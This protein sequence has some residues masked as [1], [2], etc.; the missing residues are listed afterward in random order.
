MSQRRQAGKSNGVKLM[1]SNGSLANGDNGSIPNGA[2]SKTPLLTR[3]QKIRTVSWK[4]LPEWLQDNIYITGGYRPQLDSYW[5]CIKSV[6]YL[7]NEFVNI[8]S[9]ALGFVLF[10]ILGAYFVWKDVLDPIAE[11]RTM[12]DVI[13]FYTFIAGALSC[14]GLSSSYHCVSC[15]S[16][17]TAAFWNRC[18]YLGIITLILGSYYPMVYYGFYCH[19]YLQI[20]Y[21]TSI[22]I[23]GFATGCVTMMKHFRTPTYRWMRTSLFLAMGLSGI[24]PIGHG[25]ITFGLKMALT[26]ISLGHMIAM[27]A[28]YVVG[29]LIYGNRIPE[30]WY[31]GKFNIWFAS[32]QI[33]H[34]FVVIAAVTH[35]IGVSRAVAF[36]HDP[37]NAGICEKY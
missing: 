26:S 27:G 18:D 29:A 24:I 33:F 10:C 35:Y 36:W 8:W 3:A 12:W 6:T 2:D 7:H 31:P 17:P 14:L 19:P 13:F 34:V 22:S 30:R 4:E 15:H 5:E 37:N 21:M 28:F 32:H 1:N 25:V 20:F 11:T 9:H 16:E 23:I